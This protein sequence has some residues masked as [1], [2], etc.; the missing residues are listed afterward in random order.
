MT[1]IYGNESAQ[2]VADQRDANLFPSDGAKA[3]LEISQVE[4]IVAGNEEAE[5]LVLFTD[6]LMANESEVTTATAESVQRNLSTVGKVYN[7]PSTVGLVAGCESAADE[8]AVIVAGNEGAVD[9]LKSAWEFIL[10]N[11][12]KFKRTI[13]KLFLSGL[14]AIRGL[15]KSLEAV[16]KELEGLEKIKYKEVKLDEKKVAEFK[17][18]FAIASENADGKLEWSEKVVAAITADVA[19][20]S[21]T[22]ES[23]KA[24]FAKAIKKIKGS[25]VE[26]V[27]D[28]FLTGMSKAKLVNIGSELVLHAPKSAVVARSHDKSLDDV[29]V[30]K[31]YNAGNRVVTLTVAKQAGKLKM[32]IDS[33][34]VETVFKALESDKVVKAESV[35]KLATAAAKVEI[36]KTNVLVEDM[37]KGLE[38]IGKTLSD[39]KDDTDKAI[40]AGMA[41]IKPLAQSML[42]AAQKLDR[43]TIGT[44][45]DTKASVLAY[46]EW[47]LK[48]LKAKSETKKDK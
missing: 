29:I 7:M 23:I 19:S 16:A 1:F 38:D 24:A 44:T 27:S 42:S 26:Q 37:A 3:D 41:A 34:K 18:R 14:A 10:N 15:D 20:V 13:K 43:A 28:E 25:T 46:A 40:I 22:E 11:A 8:M 2:T 47:M 33:T 21:N 4:D 45:Y 31:V 36:G 12:N 9:V 39:A 17:R 48:E 6:K 30:Y 32:F 35:A 5:E